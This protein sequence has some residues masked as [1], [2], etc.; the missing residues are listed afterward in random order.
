M[1]TGPIRGESVDHSFRMYMC[2]YVY[3]I[4]IYV[5]IKCLDGSRDIGGCKRG[6]FENQR[7]DA[8]VMNIAGRSI[9]VFE[10]V[11]PES[12]LGTIDSNSTKL[13]TGRCITLASALATSYK[14]NKERKMMNDGNPAAGTGSSCKSFQTTPSSITCSS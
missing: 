2:I 5:F 14:S 11:H 12:V 9:V 8:G 7:D 4:Y 13:S 3:Y 10:M 1:M 6:I